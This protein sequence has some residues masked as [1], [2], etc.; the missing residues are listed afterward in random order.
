MQKDSFP[1]KWQQTPGKPRPNWSILTQ[2]SPAKTAEHTTR[3]I[4][5][6]KTGFK[7]R[8]DIL[9]QKPDPNLEDYST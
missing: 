6:L 4:A 3:L 5:Q 8:K 7:A 2:N 9:I 1:G